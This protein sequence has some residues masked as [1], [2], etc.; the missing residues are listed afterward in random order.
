MDM[1]V[2]GRVLAPQGT[3][4]LPP[5]HVCGSLTRLGISFQPDSVAASGLVVQSGDSGLVPAPGTRCDSPPPSRVHVTLC[6]TWG[7]L[8]SSIYI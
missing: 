2:R 1:G 6:Q 4:K 5:S 7:P 3:R 8:L